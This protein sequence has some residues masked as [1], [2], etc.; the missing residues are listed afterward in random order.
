M[1]AVE[2]EGNGMVGG[3]FVLDCNHPEAGLVGVKGWLARTSSGSIGGKPA[4]IAFPM[5]D[6]E[7]AAVSGMS[8]PRSISCSLGLFVIIIKSPLLFADVSTVLKL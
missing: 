7:P 4:F 2:P 6:A 8:A 1:S 3:S 5:N